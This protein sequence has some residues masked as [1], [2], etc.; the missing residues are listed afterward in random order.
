MTTE[1]LE[2]PH[3]NAYLYVDFSYAAGTT[4]YTD[5]ASPSDGT[6]TF[7]PKLGVKVADNTGTFEEKTTTIELPY[8]DAFTTMIGAGDPLP[9]IYVKVRERLEDPLGVVTAQE[10]VLFR[11]R[12]TRVA[13]NY[14]GR[15]GAI[16]IQALSL[17]VNLQTPLGLVC[18]QQCVWNFGG[19]GCGV[20]LGPLVKTGTC[21]VIG[22]D[23]RVTI[24]GLAAAP[25]ATYWR[26]GYVTRNGL[27]IGI[28]DWSD[29]APTI[30]LLRERPPAE[31]VGH[32]VSVTPGCDKSYAI[33]GSRWSNHGQFGGFGIAM[34]DYHPNLEG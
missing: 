33:C 5:W 17:K 31:W 9:P 13:R 3:K 25:D 8:G 11:G 2:L 26:A 24:T 16:V 6:Y 1:I 28:R 27:K 12:V 32:A 34:P 22:T 7:E 15:K 23:R 29:S 20:A 4:K 10:L 18:T 14:Q 21:T 30:F 19:R